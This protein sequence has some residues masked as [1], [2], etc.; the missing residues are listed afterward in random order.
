MRQV[1]YSPANAPMITEKPVS[2]TARYT[3]PQ[4]A[5]RATR[6]PHRAALQLLPAHPPP[7]TAVPVFPN[8]QHLSDTHNLQPPHPGWH[9]QRYGSDRKPDTIARLGRLAEMRAA[10][11]RRT[12]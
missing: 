12:L 9:M 11:R 7:R 1:P 10:Q 4:T 8:T 2:P 3:P 6:L 5:S